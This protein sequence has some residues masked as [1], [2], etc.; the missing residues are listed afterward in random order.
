MGEVLYTPSPYVGFQVQKCSAVL[1]C[2]RNT[3]IMKPYSPTE[4]LVPPTILVRVRGSGLGFWNLVG[5]TRDLVGRRI[6]GTYTS[7]RSYAPSHSYNIRTVRIVL[8]GVS[9]N[10]IR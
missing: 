2:G 1:F 9:H 6:I 10:Y 5:G 3:S 8:N 4:S 7:I